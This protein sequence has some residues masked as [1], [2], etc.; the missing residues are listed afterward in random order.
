MVLSQQV[1]LHPDGLPPNESVKAWHLHTQEGYSLNDT[2]EEVVNMKG[3]TPGRKALRD[4]IDR[5]T[6]TGAVETK[7]KN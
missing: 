1:V 2:A 3:E 4:A 7:Y 5:A 6:A